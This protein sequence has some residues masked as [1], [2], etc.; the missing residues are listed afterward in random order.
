MEQIYTICQAIENNDPDNFALLWIFKDALIPY[1]FDC[2]VEYLN[3]LFPNS[4][5]QR[6]VEF[7][8][9]RCHGINGK[10]YNVNLNHKMLYYNFVFWNKYY[11]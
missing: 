7:L 1:D 3:H 6:L 5:S 2:D 8:N 9:V 11:I 4:I 10:F